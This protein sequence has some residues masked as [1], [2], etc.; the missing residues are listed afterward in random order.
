M[1]LD[2]RS[3]AGPQR[4][5]HNVQ[6]AD[7]QLHALVRP[8][9]SALRWC[10]ASCRRRRKPQPVPAAETLAVRPWWQRYQMEGEAGLQERS[11]EAKSDCAGT[12]VPTNTGAPLKMFGPVLHFKLD[13]RERRPADPAVRPMPLQRQ[14]PPSR[15]PRL[16]ETAPM[17][18][19]RDRQPRQPRIHGRATPGTR[20]RHQ[21]D[22]W[23]RR[24]VSSR[25]PSV[26]LTNSRPLT[27]RPIPSDST[28]QPP[29]RQPR[30][31]ISESPAGPPP[32]VG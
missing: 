3:M 22:P 28:S 11:R 31:K 16:R 5:H 7:R 32:S 24:S 10:T 15:G 9:P 18:S 23:R 13:I 2:G 6:H 17:G 20:D 29:N 14:S 8:R 26:P 25:S 12:R 21:R 4:I 1:R 19:P 30:E 27:P